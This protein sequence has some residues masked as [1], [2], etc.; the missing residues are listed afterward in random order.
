MAPAREVFFAQVSQASPDGERLRGALCLQHRDF[1]ADLIQAVFFCLSAFSQ[2]LSREPPR[3]LFSG[4][5]ALPQSPAW[6]SSVSGASGYIL[7]GRSE[8][9]ERA[10]FRGGRI[11]RSCGAGRLPLAY[12]VSDGP[13]L[14]LS[15][16]RCEVF[17]VLKERLRDGRGDRLLF[18]Q[19]RRNFSRAVF[20]CRS[21]RHLLLVQYTTKAHTAPEFSLTDGRNKIILWW[22]SRERGR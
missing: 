5:V 10:A 17:Q 7:R 18:F 12:P 3:G 9:L 15:Q 13:V 20:S 11:L 14:L 1:F 22:K 2:D 21:R 6:M 19:H 8:H 16:V 4:E